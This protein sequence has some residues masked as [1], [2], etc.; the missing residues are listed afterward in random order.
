MVVKASNNSGAV[1]SCLLY[2]F[3]FATWT[4]GF[5]HFL[6]KTLVTK[7]ISELWLTRFR[8]FVIFSMT[9][10]YCF[11]WVSFLV[12]LVST[13]IFNASFFNE[14]SNMDPSQ[15]AKVII[16]LVFFPLIVVAY[17]LML[18]LHHKCIISLEQIRDVKKEEAIA[19]E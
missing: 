19:T 10:S 11:F 12:M 4:L 5:I 18:W 2:W 14:L 17:A 13:A 3:L 16:L 7:K 1:V 15:Q 9:A 6:F 8:F